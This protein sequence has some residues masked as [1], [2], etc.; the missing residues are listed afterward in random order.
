MAFHWPNCVIKAGS[1]QISCCL[2]V[3]SV[4][5]RIKSMRA[6]ENNINQMSSNVRL[7]HGW[8]GDGE[9]NPVCLCVISL[10]VMLLKSVGP[11]GGSGSV[12]CLWF[13]SLWFY[14][15]TLNGLSCL[16]PRW[17]RHS[18]AEPL[19]DSEWQVGGFV[20]WQTGWQENKRTPRQ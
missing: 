12:F 1:W 10:I 2:R 14:H 11:V 19:I 15:S 7:H 20:S 17:L 3:D 9:N 16:L 6:K 13:T 8:E 18:I 4:C 5:M